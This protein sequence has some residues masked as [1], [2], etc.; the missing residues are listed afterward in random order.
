MDTEAIALPVI[1]IKGQKS[2][3]IRLA[4]I[5][6]PKVPAMASKFK[7]TR[8]MNSLNGVASP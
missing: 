3:A 8:S 6:A 1:R 2:L 7:S 5:D 4:N